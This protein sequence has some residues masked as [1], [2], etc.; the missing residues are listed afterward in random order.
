MALIF[1]FTGLVVVLPIV[2][3]L[4]YRPTPW[5]KC[6]HC[7]QTHALDRQPRP[8]A[9]KALFF[10]TPVRYYKCHSCLKQF[11]QVRV[12]TAD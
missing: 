7:K 5:P 2:L 4:F 8:A 12:S 9:V 1:V 11:V 6:P 3:A 10:Y